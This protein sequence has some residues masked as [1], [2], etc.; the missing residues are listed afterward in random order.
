MFVTD[1]RAIRAFP[2]L[3]RLVHD[4]YSKPLPKELQRR[5]QYEYHLVRGI[6]R[7]LR[8]RPDIIV[9][10]TD[11]SKVFYIGKAE[12]FERKAHEYM[13]KT[14]AYE[15]IP[16]NRSPLAENLRAVQTLLAYLVSKKALTQKQ[17]KRLGPKLDKLELAHYHGLPKPHKVRQ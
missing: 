1:R 3:E 12:E 5:A 14:A 11:K 8:R 4:I 16:E 2:I 7:L 15:E 13:A 9:R 17:A 6:C 10:R